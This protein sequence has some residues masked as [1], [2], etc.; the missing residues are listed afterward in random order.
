MGG[1]RHIVRWQAAV[2]SSTA[3]EMKWARNM[4]WTSSGDLRFAERVD[5]RNWAGGESISDLFVSGLRFL[6]LVEEF[7]R[8]QDSFG[9]L[10]VL[11]TLHLQRDA[12]LVLNFPAEDG[13]YEETDSIVFSPMQRT[14]WPSIG[15]K[16]PQAEQQACSSSAEGRNQQEYPKLLNRHSANKHRRSKAAGRVHAGSC[17]V[18]AQEVDSY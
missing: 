1:D 13:R 9:S 15:R 10:N 4:E 7:Y 3:P 2:D 18:D 11:H 8:N 16:R 5:R 12:K 17:N 6:N 14:R